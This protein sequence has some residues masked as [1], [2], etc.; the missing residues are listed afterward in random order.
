MYKIDRKK[1]VVME[2]ANKKKKKRTEKK[3]T[4]SAGIFY[5]WE[6]IFTEVKL[7]EICTI[8]TKNK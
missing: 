6:T 4:E 2:F 3:A 7:H 1:N 5:E 8:V